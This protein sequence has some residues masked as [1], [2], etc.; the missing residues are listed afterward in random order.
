MQKRL[1]SAVLAAAL[2]FSAVPVFA[3]GSTNEKDK[4]PPAE[5]ITVT[6]AGPISEIPEHPGYNDTV[7][8]WAAD[9]VG[10]FHT[11]GLLPGGEAF[12]P[13]QSITRGE[14]A[15]LL[16]RIMHYKTI[17]DIP[18][19]DTYGHPYEEEMQK[20]RAA[21]VMLGDELGRALPDTPVTR[22][23]AM[24]LI[25]RA[26][27]FAPADYKLPDNHEAQDDPQ[28][29]TFVYADYET[30][31]DW[32]RGYIIAMTDA[33]FLHGSDGGNFFPLDSLT[34]A[35]AVTVLSNM[36]TT[37]IDKPGEYNYRPFEGLA[38]FV[39]IAS[40]DVTIKNYDIGGNIILTEGVDHETVLFKTC[41]HYGK[42]YSYTAGGFV[43]YL[44]AASYIVP[45]NPQLPVCS[46]DTDLFLKDEKGIMHYLDDTRP[47][48]FGVDV[49]SW[50]GD[51]NWQKLKEEGVYFAFIRVGYRGYESGKLNKD[52]YFEK[53]IKGALEAGIKVGVYFFSQ[54]LNAQ[55]A[56]DEAVYLLDMIKGY[57]ITFPVVFDWETINASS[58]RTNGIETDALC[59]AANVF[60][61]TVE[62]AGYIP[63]V[64]CNQSVSLLY[65][66][67]SR[68]DNYDFWYAEYKD[69]PTFYYDF[70]IWQY[71]CTGNFEGVPH[72]DLDVNISFVDYS[73]IDKSNG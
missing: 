41:N 66:E 52:E 50:Q 57:N 69:K 37:Y 36:I 30:I 15:W 29:E 45:I 58:A 1:L 39:I 23:E 42:I 43:R 33:G 53:N 5:Y 7:G 13:D 26:F 62:E 67:L 27:G 21:G 56:Y 63:M 65:Y 11:L 2:L 48:W 64:Y 16:T 54:A 20:L 59:Q 55:E 9:A 71:G 73:A 12:L 68:I 35:E 8:H 14:V 22:E 25:A 19:A 32:A 46:Y 31:S 24:V 38:D 40:D 47:H 4:T 61:S 51:V 44:K 10:R 28:A 34:R 60:C 6:T 17:S 18:F 70:D 3:A 72:A 49:S